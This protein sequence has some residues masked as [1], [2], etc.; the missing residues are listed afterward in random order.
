[1]VIGV[2]AFAEKRAALA[3][4]DRPLCI[5]TILHPSPASPLA[6]RGWAGLVR[7]QL[8]ALGVD[9]P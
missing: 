6:N 7:K 5:G 4:S 1:M 2:G 8:Q 9:L 3:L